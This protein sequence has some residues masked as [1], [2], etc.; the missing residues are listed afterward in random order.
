MAPPASGGYD[1]GGR[2]SLRAPRL[3][4][5]P[6]ALPRA[7]GS[8]MSDPQRTHQFTLLL[9]DAA[10]GRKEA[11]EEL[12]TLV[13]DEL[14]GIAEARMARERPGHTL[15]ATDLVH[16][17]YVR[18]SAELEAGALQNRAHFFHAA[19]EAMRRILID[20]AR[21]RG[22]LKRGGGRQRV[23]ITSVD[24]AAEEGTSEVEML[25]EAIR[26]LEA[27]DPRLGKVVRLRYFA[28]L[29]T[30]ETAGVL[31]VSPR[32]VKRDWTFARAWLREALGGGASED[33]SD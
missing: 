30:E 3:W 17:A 13:Y 24:L 8:R 25:D 14:R 1:P 23:S 19:A 31:D 22:R 2:L 32:T 20:H 26:S 16:E 28:G 7:I 33:A 4:W 18:L 21:R 12:I 6:E 9:R 11:S 29:S 27:S 10:S 15:Q 5:T